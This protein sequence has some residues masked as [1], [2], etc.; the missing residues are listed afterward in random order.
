MTEVLWAMGKKGVIQ[1]MSAKA[2]I[3]GKVVPG[4]TIVKLWASGYWR[5][6]GKDTLVEARLATGGNNATWKD[7]K[8][9]G[10]EL[11]IK[12]GENRDLA[13]IEMFEWRAGAPDLQVGLVQVN[14]PK[15]VND[16]LELV[17][18]S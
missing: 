15:Y 4:G 7:L 14:R 8:D 18:G 13:F 9:I 2:V 5:E 3:D 16:F 1:D 12:G 10:K 17:C 11:V 6:D